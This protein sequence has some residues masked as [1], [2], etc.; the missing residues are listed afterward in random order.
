M[1][2]TA[3]VKFTAKEVLAA[4]GLPASTKM[5]SAQAQYQGSLI[6]TVEH[7]ELID[8]DGMRPPVVD[9]HFGHAE[10]AFR[11][12]QKPPVLMGEDGAAHR[13]ELQARRDKNDG[14]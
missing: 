12:D 2:R 6:L 5:V 14:K 13:K 10:D 4:L 3:R 7:A 1:P 11:W 9:P 8:H